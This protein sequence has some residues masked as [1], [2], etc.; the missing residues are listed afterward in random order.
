M[1]QNRSYFMRSISIA[2][3]VVFLLVSILACTE[4][5]SAASKLKVSVTKKT[6][7][8][9]QT[10]KL[11][12]NKNVKW[13]VSNKKVGKLTSIKKKSVTVKG[14]KAGT[15]YVKA[16]YGKKVKKIK[17]TV[18]SRIPK[19][20]NLTATK[21]I[22]GVGDYC[23]VSVES[24]KPSY[25][26]TDVTFSSSDTSVATVNSSGFVA[27]LKP[28]TA[29]IIATS[30]KDKNKKA[31]ID[32]TVVPTKAGTV[33]L[34]VDL[35]DETRYPAGKVARV[36]LPVPQTDD[37][38]K[39][40]SVKCDAPGAKEV[41]L[42]TDTAGG[43]QYYIE[44][45]EN[46]P[47]TERKA[48]MSYHLY[49]KAIVRRDSIESNKST[50]D[51]VDKTKFAEELKETYWSGDLKSGIVKETADKIV[52]DAGN[53]VYE[54][55]FAIYDYICNNMVRTD[56]KKVILG[57]VVSIL[58]GKREAG[59]CMDVNA[60]FVSL[61][62]AEGIPA[63]TLYGFN[64]IYLSPNCRAEFYLPD[65]GW[66]VVDPAMSIRVG[67]GLDAPPKTDNDPEWKAAKDAYWG[68]ASET[69]IGIN[70]G[71]DFMLNPPQRADTG[72]EY[73]EVLNPD[74]TINIYMFPYGEYDDEYIPCMGRDKN[75]N[76]KYEF[77]FE[78]ED[79]LDCGC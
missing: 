72:G 75:E 41:K 62:R 2:V 65:Y 20:I 35:S 43:Q 19:E 48:E 61:C 13:S 74:G 26:S 31:S 55:A 9:G 11:K 12:A 33:N 30:K 7:Y 38:Q 27:G 14:L 44:W 28:G 70:M 67:R 3:T 29:S 51:D 17:I 5:V 4:S 63:R 25:A 6:I 8:V 46:T 16:K 69:W 60:V 64:F 1:Q 23:T 22:L 49:R 54:Q 50:I 66:V 34:Q 56:N 18:R 37:N 68:N 71:H 53:T 57:D 77:K 78:E 32:I 59:S 15:V 45:D 79:P 47:P 52:A 10:A 58:E 36:W 42:T 76:F 21:D 39:I 40:T 73:L 24:V